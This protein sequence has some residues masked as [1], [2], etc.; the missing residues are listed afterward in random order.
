MV[1]SQPNYFLSFYIKE[2]VEKD[3]ERMKSTMTRTGLQIFQVLLWSIY[4]LCV[5]QENMY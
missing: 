5:M 3:E 4:L 1:F 2:P